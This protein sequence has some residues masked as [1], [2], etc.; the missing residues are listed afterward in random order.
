[1]KSLKSAI[2]CFLFLAVC[3]FLP[4]QESKFRSGIV[5]VTVDNG[6]SHGFHEGD[7]DTELS[8][9]GIKRYQ[10]ILSKFKKTYPKVN[11]DSYKKLCRTYELYFDSKLDVENQMKRLKNTGLFEVVEPAFV[12]SILSDGYLPNDPLSDSTLAA[13]V[14][15][16]Q[17]L[18][19]DFYKA[20]TVQ[21]GDTNVVIGVVDTGVNFDQEDLKG[22]LKY[23][24]ADP[25]DGVNNDG[26]VL[27]G[28]SLLEDI[29]LVDNFRGWDLGDNDN[30]PTEAPGAKHGTEMI[31]IIASTPDNDTAM[32]GVAFN[33]KYLPIKA[34]ADATPNALTQGYVGMIY[35]AEQGARV[36]NC[37]WGTTNELPEIFDLLV[38][39]LTLDYDLLIVS[40]AGNEG[41]EKNYYPA[42][43]NHV[44]SVSGMDYDSA[45]TASSSYNYEVDVMAAG[46]TKVANGDQTNTY[47]IENGTSGAAAVV[48]GLA[49]LVRSQLPHLTAVQVKKQLEVSGDYIDTVSAILPFSGK[50]GRRINPYSALTDTMLP[51]L[52]PFDFVIND[53]VQ[54]VNNQGDVV[55]VKFSL[56][57]LLK[58][59][60]DVSYK[61]S[62]LTNDFEVIDSIGVFPDLNTWDTILSLPEVN[63]NVFATTDT[64]LECVLKVEMEDGNGYI[65]H[66]YV[67]FTLKPTEITSVDEQVVT[68]NV[69]VFPNPFN[70]EIS[71]HGLEGMSDVSLF[72]MRGERLL[73]SV[74]AD[75]NMTRVLPKQT[76]EQGV[77]L[78]EMTSK[79]VVFT[80]KIIKVNP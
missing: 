50:V 42:S 46:F 26:D 44:I 41:N 7:Y 63:I 77:Y 75:G 31:S 1:M 73:A 37:S 67:R 8:S 70:N 25:I 80:K 10:C 39:S 55:G 65:D 49:G 47:R 74:V 64:L 29:P 61:I 30:D 38:T 9:L 54:E 21:K 51:G 16:P 78:L 17:L 2:L 69:H 62:A 28:D 58:E 5:Y 3:F 27:D 19:H 59:S 24:Y 34:S 33:C 13:N 71:I 6:L 4:A 43:F 76:L 40:A 15:M 53:G 32:T 22:N 14:G 79:D 57:N 45:K 12:F 68:N 35:A 36:V 18:L 72:N 48:S 52:K 66:E 56:V 11:S 23:N 60:S 20:W